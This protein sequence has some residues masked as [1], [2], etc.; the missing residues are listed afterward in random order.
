MEEAAARKRVEALSKELDGV[1]DDL[2]ATKRTNEMDFGESSSMFLDS[3]SFNVNKTSDL[4]TDESTK[5]TLRNLNGSS[6][7]NLKTEMDRIPALEDN[8]AVNNDKS[9]STKLAV[10]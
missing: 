8:T 7:I 6:S 2:G 5:E 1:K 10:K 9:I 3:K 4:A